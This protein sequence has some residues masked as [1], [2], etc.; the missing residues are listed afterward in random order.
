MQKIQGKA[1][2]D[3]EQILAYVGRN[4]G[5]SQI[6]SGLLIQTPKTMSLS[7]IMALC[8]LSWNLDNAV[9]QLFAHPHLPLNL[10]PRD[11]GCPHRRT[12]TF[13]IFYS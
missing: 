8:N 6:R 5:L 10:D 2:G 13:F 7:N 1:R 3:T 11:C 9:A 12:T 4:V